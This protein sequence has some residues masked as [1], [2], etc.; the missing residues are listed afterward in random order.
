MYER[1]LQIDPRNHLLLNNYSYSLAERG[2]QLDRALSMS[3]QAVSQQPENQSYLDTYGWIFY[4]MG[5]FREAEQWIRKAID[6]GSKS[7]VVNEHLGDVYSKLSE[8]EK[9][10]EYWEKALKI[11]SNNQSVRDKIRRGSL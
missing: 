9:A 5:N 3:K 11:D 6:L 4:M 2:I 1:A 10:I 8:K 7:A